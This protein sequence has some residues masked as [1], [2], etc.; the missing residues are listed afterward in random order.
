ML[1]PYACLFGAIR[2]S[3]N[4][5]DAAWNAT[6]ILVLAPTIDPGTFRVIET[7][8][9]ETQPDSAIRLAALTPAR[10]T[11]EKLSELSKD[12]S[13]PFAGSKPFEAPPPVSKNDR[14]LV[15]LRRDGTLPEYTPRPDLPV[16]TNGWQPAGSFGDLR[17]STVW[18][19]DGLMYGFVQ[20]INPGPT[21]LVRLRQNEGELRAEI[22]VVLRER[23]AMDRATATIDPMLRSQ[24]LA[25]LV[26][27]SN[28]TT[29]LSAL[30]KLGSEGR[31]GAE[32]LFELL[33]N[34]SLLGLHSSIISVM[35]KTGYG[36]THFASL[37]K[38]ETLYWLS[39]CATLKLG[40]WNDVSHYDEIQR[41]RNHYGRAYALLTATQVSGSADLMPAVKEFAAIWVS[42]P[43][44]GSPKEDDQIMVELTNLIGPSPQ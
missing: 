32:V 41:P 12:F 29:Q 44:I 18:M 21:H 40:W 34:D 7:I 17:T 19:Q 20:T 22:N 38:E 15:L 16:D 14:L 2:P 31:E 26:R 6:D 43:A 8:K 1:L 4:L 10:G 28:I 37:L 24:Q 27:S 25:A 39:A 36:G 33:S 23:D 3:F 13:D 35:A 9:G 42:C 30:G 5:H 11:S